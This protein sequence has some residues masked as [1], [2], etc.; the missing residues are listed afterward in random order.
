VTL[1]AD[2]IKA[3]CATAY[4]SAAAR[5][6]LGD[7]FH[8]GGAAL[9][10]R[11]ARA[12]EVGLGD[13]VVDVACGPGTSALQLARETGCGVIGVDLAPPAASDDPRVR[14]VRGD[15]ESLPLEDA[16]VEGALCECALCTFP[17]KAAAASE[18][19]RVLRPGARLALSDLTARPEELPASLTSLTAWVACVADARPLEQIAAFLEQAGLV[20]EHTERHD[21]A[22]VELVERIEARLKVAKLLAPDAAAGAGELLREVRDALD[23]GVLGYGLVIARRP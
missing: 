8:P 7:C 17:D 11:L 10:S 4:S 6:L 21:D 2:E 16:S 3:C 13:V 5:F 12:L 18:L 23:A 15:A 14:F 20:V 9:T 22:L 1:A 19:A